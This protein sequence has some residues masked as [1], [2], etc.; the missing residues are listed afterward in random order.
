MKTILLVCSAGMS[1]SMLV[2]RMKKAALEKG[3]DVEIMAIGIAAVDDSLDIPNLGCILVGPQARYGLDA[4]ETYS[5]E[6][7]YKCDM[8]PPDLYGTFDGEKVL[9]FAIETMEN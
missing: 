5:E 2:E 4:V 6:H 1:T 7:G 9:D 3:L 8:I